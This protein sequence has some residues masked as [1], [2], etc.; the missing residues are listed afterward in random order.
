[1]ASISGVRARLEFPA[2][3]AAPHIDKVP[4]PRLLRA[5]RRLSMQDLPKCPSLFY[6]HRK[7][8]RCPVGGIGR[9]TWFRSKRESMGVRVPH[10]APS[11]PSRPRSSRNSRFARDA[12]L[13]CRY[14]TA[15]IRAA[16]LYSRH[17]VAPAVKSQGVRGLV[18]ARTSGKTRAESSTEFETAYSSSQRCFDRIG[19]TP[20]PGCQSSL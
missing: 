16:A 11:P 17:Q 6:R 19:N 7:P 4:E 10:R 1:M 18:P 9:H 8:I 14:R 15:Q 5:A 13:P 2:L 12:H 20:P 3:P